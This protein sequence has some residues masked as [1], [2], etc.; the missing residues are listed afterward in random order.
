MIIIVSGSTATGKTTIAGALARKL[1]Y[2]Y[3]DVNKLIKERGLREKYTKKLDSYEVDT[4]KL[5]KILLVL[6]KKSK[7]LIIDSHL[8]H[9]L[10]G[11]YVGLCIICK[12][13]LNVLIY[14][15]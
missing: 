7:S 5:N 2:K 9:Y 6:I 10:P 15:S 3:L 8:S 13:N 12:C 1:K 11:K 14:I 4:K